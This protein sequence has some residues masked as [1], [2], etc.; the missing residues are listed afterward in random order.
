MTIV[1]ESGAYIV[2]NG[3]VLVSYPLNR[4]VVE[5]VFTY[6]EE[7]QFS[8]EAIICGETAAYLLSSAAPETKVF[9]KTYYTALEEVDDF[10]K[11]PDD[12][13]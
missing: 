10:S 3:K 8:Q 7:H 2:E 9:F 1:S 4:E 12:A 5:K 11:L 13:F 6:L